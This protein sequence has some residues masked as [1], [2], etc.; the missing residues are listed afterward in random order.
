MRAKQLMQNYGEL[1]D[2]AAGDYLANLF[3]APIRIKD[4]REIIYKDEQKE[5]I[6]RETKEYNGEICQSKCSSAFPSETNHALSASFILPSLI[7]HFLGNALEN[8]ILSEGLNKLKFRKIEWK[9]WEE[10]QIVESLCGTPK[11]RISFNATKEYVLG[12]LY[13]FFVRNGIMEA[14]LDNELMFTGICCRKDRKVRRMLGDILS[15]RYAMKRIRPEYLFLLRVM[16]DGDKL[17]LRNSIMHGSSETF[18]YFDLRFVA[19]MYQ[20]I[21]DISNGDLFQCD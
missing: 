9:D 2:K 10:K 4:S 1:Y 15:S 11:D 17:N 6:V 18:D 5:G 21:L 3:G 14:K 8:Q 12:R 20:I 19:V 13:H 7:E 16:F